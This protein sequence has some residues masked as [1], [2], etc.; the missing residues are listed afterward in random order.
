MPKLVLQDT[1]VEKP[2][3]YGF[4]ET[5]FTL[6]PYFSSKIEEISYA[7]LEKKLKV[8]LQMLLSSY[9]YLKNKEETSLWWKICTGML[10][11]ICA[12]RVD[13]NDGAFFNEII[14]HIGV[15]TRKEVVGEIRMIN[16]EI[17]EYLKERGEVKDVTNLDLLIY[18]AFAC[19]K[20]VLC[21]DFENAGEETANLIVHLDKKLLSGEK[22]SREGKWSE[23]IE[24]NKKMFLSK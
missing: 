3:I 13:I 23:A 5:A 22:L 6:T 4:L 8:H 1:V 20:E 10:N 21:E 2:F 24:A 11:P 15:S 18:S 12:L 9:N 7:T 17:E 14:K 16:K 19:Q